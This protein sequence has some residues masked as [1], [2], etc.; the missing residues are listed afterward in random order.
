MD[1]RFDNLVL[2]AGLAALAVPILIHL[3]KRRRHVVI[4]WGAMQFLPGSHASR[5]RRLLEEL[6]LLAVRL[7]IV[8]LV[9]LALA[10]PFSTSP[11]FARL[12]DRPARD[13]ILVLDGSY[14]MDAR[15]GEAPTPWD[16]ARAWAREHVEQ[17]GR[18]ERA[19][20]LLAR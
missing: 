14:S 2:L 12:E 1:L 5:R 8:A 3:L 20:V 16:E 10:R 4:D 18:G 11:L 7:G 13:T 9:V 19:A 17:L 6:L 15:T